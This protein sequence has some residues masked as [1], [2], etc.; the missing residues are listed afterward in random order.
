MVPGEG[1]EPTAFSMSRKRSTTELTG[2]NGREYSSNGLYQT[3]RESLAVQDFPDLAA[4]LLRVEGFFD[5]RESGVDN[6]VLSNDLSGI[7][8]HVE[9]AEL[10]PALA[11]RLHQLVAVQPGHHDVGEDQIN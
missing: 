11:K 6:V 9:C 8:G 7:A 2:R 10:R 5:E 1:I 4:D 3:R